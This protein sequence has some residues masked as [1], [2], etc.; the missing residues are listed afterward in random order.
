MLEIAVRLL[1]ECGRHEAQDGMN[2][3]NRIHACRFAAAL[4]FSTTVPAAG[5]VLPYS[6]PVD[7]RADAREY[8][9][10]VLRSYSALMDDLR[11]TWAAGDV[12][13]AIRL[14]ANE[15]TLLVEDGVLIEGRAAI[16]AYLTGMLP[17]VTELRT[18][19][20]DFVTSDRLAY[21][22]GPV[23]LLLDGDGADRQELTGTFVVL[24]VREGR[25][26][27]V[28]SQVFRFTSGSPAS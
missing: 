15:A 26:W 14:Y 13:A 3:M 23:W 12:G 10:T 25:N 17:R 7:W 5:Q 22:V 16:Q 24:A 19:L 28:R 11:R 8:T 9:S 18:G 2:A 27:R 20:T 21:G 1:A 4:L 6:P